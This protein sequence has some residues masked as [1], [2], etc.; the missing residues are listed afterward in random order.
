MTRRAP[1]HSAFRYAIRTMQG[2][3]IYWLITV[4]WL[5]HFVDEWMFG[6]P[7]WCTRHFEPAP[8]SFW[9]NV[10]TVLSV[11]MIMLGW[12]A[13][14]RSAGSAIRLFCAGVQMI[15]FS[16]AFFHLI[17][18]FVLGENSPGTATGVVLFL[19]VSLLLWRVV[20]REPRVTKNSFTW[21]WSPVLLSMAS[22]Y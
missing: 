20:L 11:P 2:R 21:R 12:T 4:Q 6:L 3:N 13:S 17:T 15:F 22:C 10:M 14:R 9:I 1:S 16:N 5:A 8:D 7:A 19:P 18:T